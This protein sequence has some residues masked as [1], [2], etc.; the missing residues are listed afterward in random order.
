MTGMHH[1]FNPIMFAG[2]ATVG[3]DILYLPA[4]L[5]PNFAQGAA[6]LAVAFKSK[7]KSLKSVAMTSAISAS[8]GGI[9]EPAIFGVTLRLKNPFIAT[10][11]GS[12]IA[13][14][15]TGI[16]GIKSYAVA[17]PGIISMIQFIAPDNGANFI[18]AIIIAIISTVVTFILTLI[19]GF[20]DI[21]EDESVKGEAI[22]TVTSPISGELI[23]LE[24]VDDI[25]FSKRML[26]DGVAVIPSEGKI[27][28]P[29]DGTIKMLFQTGHALGLISTTGVEMLIHVGLDTVKLEGKGF[30]PKIKQGAVVK[31]G[32]LLLDFDINF[33]KDEGY[34]IITPIIFTNLENINKNLTL[35]NEQKFTDVG[36]DIFKLQNRMG[37]QNGI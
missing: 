7:N 8:L 33:I 32:Q 2:L 17:A 16:L 3:F 15:F 20:K 12:G 31:K 27:Y 9:T 26:G 23:V 10:I 14:I 11:I 5:A 37:E 19:I 6:C 36:E 1:A 28:A 18:N 30:N 25:T 22:E 34:D 24:K 4:M 35:T 29:F 21:E 13:G